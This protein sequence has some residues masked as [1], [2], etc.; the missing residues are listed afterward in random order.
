MSDLRESKISFRRNIKVRFFPGARIQDIYYYLVP[1]LRNRPDKIILHIGSNDAPHIKADEMVE[2]LG[3]LNG[4][5]NGHSKRRTTLIS[6]QISFTRWNSGQ[7]LIE[8]FLI[9][10]QAISGHSN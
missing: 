1:L 3:K 2:E 4:Q 5:I 9:S 7:T 6:G 10:G 8:K